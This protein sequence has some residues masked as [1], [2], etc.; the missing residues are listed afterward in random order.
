MKMMNIHE[1]KTHLSQYIELAFNGE[2]IIIC[3][4]GKPMVK[5]VRYEEGEQPRTPGYWTGKV[6][7]S[8]D[9][10]ELPDSIA[11]AFRGED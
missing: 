9:F 2:D 11:K 10:D 4:A 3:K 1:A 6:V 5:L 7:I 8:D